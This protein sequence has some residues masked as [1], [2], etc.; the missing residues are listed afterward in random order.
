MDAEDSVL[1]LDSEG[2]D[3]TT[4]HWLFYYGHGLRKLNLQIAA[5]HLAPTLANHYDHRPLSVWCV[6][7]THTLEVSVTVCSKCNKAKKKKICLTNLR[8]S[9]WTHF[10]R[11]ALCT[12]PNFW[13]FF[14][15]FAREKKKVGQK[16]Y[17]HRILTFCIDH[18][19]KGK[20]A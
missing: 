5:S 14:F 18:F 3:S 20:N 15:F 17:K 13:P 16:Y 19:L 6:R 7:V 8:L 4:Q 9:M 1:V 10:C 2:V 11:I 12:E